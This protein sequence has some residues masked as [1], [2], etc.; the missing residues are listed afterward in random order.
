MVRDVSCPIDFHRQVDANALKTNQMTIVAVVLVAFVLGS[1]I[2]VGLILAL[3][4]ALGLGAA[5]PGAGP[6]QLLYRRVLVSRG[7]V[8]PSPQ[9]SD[10]APHRFSQ[11]MGGVVLMLAAVLLL[12]GATAVGWVLAGLVVALALVNL[13]FGFCAGCFVFL[14]LR[15]AG[16]GA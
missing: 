2:G 4:I 15:K 6:I 13:L 3:A 9:S 12:A 11:G 7:I 1:G 14:Q 10:T 8:K 5:R 16:I